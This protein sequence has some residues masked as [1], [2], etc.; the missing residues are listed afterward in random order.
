MKQNVFYLLSLPYILGGFDE[1]IYNVGQEKQRNDP[2]DRNMIIARHAIIKHLELPRSDIV[3]GLSPHLRSPLIFPLQ[4]NTFTVNYTGHPFMQSLRQNRPM[5]FLVVVA[6]GVL[7]VVASGLW[8]TLE[9]WLQLS[10]FPVGFRGP[11]LAILALDTASVFTVEVVSSWCVK[12]SDSR[13]K[14]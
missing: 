6:Y 4:I 2:E 11:L 7:I 13:G 3:C 9:S 14:G 1:N 12:R 10:P 8:P 5:F